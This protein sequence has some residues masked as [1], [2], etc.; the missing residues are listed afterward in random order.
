MSKIKKLAG[1]V[2][3]EGGPVSASSERN[4][5]CISAW[6]KTEGPRWSFLT[7]FIGCNTIHEGSALPHDLIS[8]KGSPL[9]TITLVV[10]VQYMV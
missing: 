10:R 6:L 5:C 7:S 1:L 2:S 8:S 9:H 4:E 3:S